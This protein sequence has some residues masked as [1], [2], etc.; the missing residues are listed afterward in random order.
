MA[1][2]ARL[3]AYLPQAPISIQLQPAALQVGEE[4]RVAARELLEERLLDAVDPLR[5][6]A[7]AGDAEPGLDL[8][9]APALQ[10]ALLEGGDH[11]R[12]IA[13]SR[14]HG[15]QRAVEGGPALREAHLPA[16]VL[17]GRQ[18]VE[19]GRV[20]DRQ[21][22]LAGQVDEAAADAQVQ[23]AAERHPPVGLEP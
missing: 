6:L 8:G 9:H 18:P 17:A 16:D 12:P 23:V 3:P 13:G 11:P 10:V 5:D 14:P 20:L 22:A 19:A 7:G 4:L 1:P 21:V 2:G 15:G